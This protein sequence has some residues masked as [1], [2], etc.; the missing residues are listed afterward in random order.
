LVNGIKPYPP[1]NP[2][3][4]MVNDSIGYLEEYFKEKK[5]ENIVRIKDITSFSITIDHLKK[6]IKN[7]SNTIKVNNENKSRNV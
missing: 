6:E 4:M 5:I 1:N 3:I 7:D 2:N